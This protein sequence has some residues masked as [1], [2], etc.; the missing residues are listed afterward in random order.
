MAAS[1]GTKDVVLLLQRAE[2]DPLKLTSR[3][4]PIQ[5]GINELL[6]L[7]RDARGV[8]PDLPM[9]QGEDGVNAA[10]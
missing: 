4:P 3:R 5:C 1:N 2:H 6:A 7:L 8:E 10:Q 9:D